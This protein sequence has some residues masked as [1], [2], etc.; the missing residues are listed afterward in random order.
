MEVHSH[1]HTPRK[2]W[3]HYFWEFLMLFLAVFCGFLAENWREHYVEDRRIKQYSRSLIQ[4]LQKDTVMINIVM[5]RIRRNIRLT[6]S[7]SV[8]L[9]HRSLSQIRN[10]EMFVFSIIDRYPPYTWSRATL[11]QMKNSGSLRYFSNYNIIS[12]VS[13]YD[14]LAHHMDE[15][16]ANDDA[17]GN[18]TLETATRII[19]M[20]YPKDLVMNFLAGMLSNMD[21]IMQ[22]PWLKELR[23]KDSTALIAKNMDDMQIFLNEKVN[24]RRLLMLRGEIEL[25]RLKKQAFDLIELLKKEYHLR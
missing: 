2:K 1:T 24:L 3:T 8:Y 13:E 9:K 14:A 4:D 23:Q 20:D 16:R 19:N 25:P 10:V 17:L 21:S 12:R 18:Q 22:A 5:T 11:E 7:M 6:D 15:D